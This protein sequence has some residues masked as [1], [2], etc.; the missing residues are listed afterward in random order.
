MTN[1]YNPT[2]GR[3]IADMETVSGEARAM[4]MG[5]LGYKPETP[6]VFE[7]AWIAK[8]YEKAT[9]QQNPMRSKSTLDIAYDYIDHV[10]EEQLRKIIEGYANPADTVMVPGAP[11]PGSPAAPPAPQPSNPLAPPPVPGAGKAPK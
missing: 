10:G 8:E 5:R 11:I 6:L 4:I 7:Q 3:F 1:T 9:D 2:T